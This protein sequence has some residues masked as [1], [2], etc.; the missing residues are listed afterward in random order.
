V[1]APMSGTAR[2]RHARARW[3]F[4]TDGP[5]ADLRG[6]RPL[7]SVVLEDFALRFGD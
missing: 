3:D 5:F 1:L 6:R 7:A 2:I 4:P